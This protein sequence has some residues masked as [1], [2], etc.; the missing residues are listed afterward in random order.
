M[1]Q[2]ISLVLSHLRGYI[3]KKREI[4]SLSILLI[5]STT[6]SGCGGADN[7]GS[8][9]TAPVVSGAYLGQPG[10]GL[11]PSRFAVSFFF[12]KSHHGEN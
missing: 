10:P 9:P 7:S 12:L 3:M 4:I 5:L 1:N 2:T 6:F 11:T 8:E